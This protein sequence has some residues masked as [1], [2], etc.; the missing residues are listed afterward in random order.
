MAQIPHQHAPIVSSTDYV[1]T[2]QYRDRYD[3]MV[4]VA[5]FD[6]LGT[7]VCRIPHQHHSVAAASDHL[8]V[9]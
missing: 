6:G 4:V 2:R 8:L 9:R 1:S 3:L 7:W 5:E